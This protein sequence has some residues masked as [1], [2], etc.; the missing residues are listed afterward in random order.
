MAHHREILG[1]VASADAAVVFSEGD[2]EN[3]VQFILDTPVL[4]SGIQGGLGCD[5]L[6]R[7]DVVAALG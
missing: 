2:V 5:V 3:P 6:S 1:G 7:T 4:A